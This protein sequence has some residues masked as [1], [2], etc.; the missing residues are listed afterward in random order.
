LGKTLITVVGIS[1]WLLAGSGWA[2]PAPDYLTDLKDLI[3][4]SRYEQVLTRGQALLDSL[5]HLDPADPDHEALVLDLM[6]NAGYR[7]DQVMD[8]KFLTMAHRAIALNERNTGP[9][10]AATATSVMHLANLMS[11]RH[12]FAASLPYYEH[13]AGILE[14]LGSQ[15]D[16]QRAVILSGEGVALRRQ[17][18]LDAARQK[19]EQALAI[20]IRMLGTEHPDVAATLNNLAIIWQHLGNYRKARDLYRQ[21]LAIRETVFGPQHEWVAETLYNLSIT[22]GALG[23]YDAAIASQERCLDIFRATLGENHQRY[24]W[25]RLNLGITYLDMGDYVGALPI[26]QDVLSAQQRIYG[27]DHINTSYALDALG[28]C[29]FKAANY[30]EALRLYTRSLSLQ[31]TG[32]G[33][34]NPENALTMFEVGRCQMALGQLTAG[35]ETMQHSLALQETSIGRDSPELCDQLDRLTEVELRLAQPDTALGY[36]RRSQAILAAAVGTEHPLYAEATLLAAQALAAAGDTT[37]AVSLALAAENIS[38]RHLQTTMRVLSEARALDYATDR[39]RGLDLALSLIRCGVPN[40]QVGQVWDTLIHSRAVVLDE[41][42][43]RNMTLSSQ[44]DSLATALLDSSLVLREHL[45][46]LTLRGVG[47]GDA[48][49]YIQ[50]LAECRRDLD[51]L[52][53]RISLTDSHTGLARAARDLGRNEVLN[54]LP[55]GSVLISYVLY[56]RPVGDPAENAHEDHLMAIVADSHQGEPIAIELGP[57][58]AITILVRNWHDQILFGA[59]SARPVVAEHTRG[60]VQVSHSQD[61]N[62]ASYRQ[63][64]L[65]LRTAV[66]DPLVDLI[67]DAERV[68]IVPDGVL[69]RVNFGALP[70]DSGLYLAEE[71]PVLHTLMTERSVVQFSHQIPFRPGVLA[72]GD[73]DFGVP[74]T[75]PA[76]EWNFLPLPHAREEVAYLT[77]VWEKT[78]ATGNHDITV[79]TGADATEKAFKADLANHGILH[80]ATHGFVVKSGSPPQTDPVGP[81]NLAG[82]ALQGANTWAHTSDARED[83]ILTASEISALDMTG[84]DWAVLSACDTGLG[85]LTARGEGVFGLCR[86]FALAGVHT[87]IVSLWPVGDTTTRDWMQALYTAHLAGGMSTDRAVQEA[88]RMVLAD[89]RANGLSVHPYFW[90]GFTAIGDWQ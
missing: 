10:S 60:L 67:T 59:R 35:A 83:G 34:D 12:E 68:L 51:Q 24:L 21:A 7:T 66:W 65:A 5:S 38:R 64:A 77:K 46:N 89:R 55:S 39:V 90:A 56:R 8:E 18:N 16:Q 85:E 29:H 58:D 37:Q 13:A 82:L 40:P 15:Y 47:P 48:T 11:C 57:A 31:E 19:Y 53:R 22:E 27:P 88:N 45:A 84:V 33:V 6:V 76:S 20:Q 61:S 69:H 79:L 87:V 73:P 42:T 17:G 30:Q 50:T 4:N 86:A 2:D 72:V 9:T 41:F 49:T 74:A 62:L 71:G 32:L 52:D 36:A 14:T 43:A 28:S 3:L 63:A 23:D 54:A 26:C 78:S 75:N 1:I 70:A 81:L 25:A 80:L 44:T